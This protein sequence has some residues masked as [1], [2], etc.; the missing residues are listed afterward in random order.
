MAAAPPRTQPAERR[1][2]AA[3]PWRRTGDR[4]EFLLVTSRE[5]RRWVTPKGGRMTGFSDAESAALEALEEAG[6]EGR[7]TAAPIG[8]FRY[9]KVLKR[10][11]PRWCV[12][13]LHAL[14]VRVE[15]ETWHEQ[16]QRDRAWVSR[17]EAVRRVDEPDLKALI[18]AFDG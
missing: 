9:L 4:L 2:V 7:I 13:S 3:L 14:E 15:H 16:G 18:A 12:V 1:Q 6:I 10:R 17:D 11:A 8:T 5:T